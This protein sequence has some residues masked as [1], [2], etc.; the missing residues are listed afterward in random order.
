M[1]S[2]MS[3]SEGTQP[4]NAEDFEIHLEEDLPEE[5]SSTAE[6]LVVIPDAVGFEIDRQALQGST[7]IRIGI[8]VG[9]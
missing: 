2:Q 6:V 9:R 1:N 4:E 5:Q 3:P 7:C 8:E